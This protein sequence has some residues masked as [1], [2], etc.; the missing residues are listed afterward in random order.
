MARTLILTG[1]SRG[2]GRALALALSQAGVQLVLNARSEPE[3][4]ASA[5]LVKARGGQ[6]LALAGDCSHGDVAQNLVSAAQDL[7]GFYGFIHCAGVLH[8]GPLLSELPESEFREII[9]SHLTAAYQLLRFSVPALETAQA[10]LAVFFGSG[11][12]ERPGVGTAAYA[13]AKAAEEHLMRQ[14][15]LELPWLTTLVYRPG[16]VETKMQQ[17][18]RTTQR[19]GGAAEVRRVF[20]GYQSRLATPEQAAQAL[21]RI[22]AEPQKFRG[23]IATIADGQEKK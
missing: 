21:V 2:I 14:V 20:G 8:P 4:S 12:A 9:D 16:V 15:A 10:G 11:L 1:A 5:N 17:D 6:A 19:G 3:L 7:G 13:I 18:S 23:K 22:L